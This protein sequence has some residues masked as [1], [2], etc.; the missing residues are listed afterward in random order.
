[1]IFG[2]IVSPSL[3]AG[4][5]FQRQSLFLEGENIWHK[6]KLISA[7]DER[8]QKSTRKSSTENLSRGDSISLRTLVY[9]NAISWHDARSS[10]VYF[11]LVLNSSKRRCLPLNF[12]EC[13]FKIHRGWWQWR[14]RT[15]PDD[16]AN[17]TSVL[18]AHAQGCRLSSCCDCVKI[19]SF[20]TMMWHVSFLL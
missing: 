11:M 19:Q 14:K 5:I 3:R 10:T 4:E 7:W 12:A 1:M 2:L 8:S 16:Y 9:I 17:G 15:L 18:L 13:Y 20:T 6:I